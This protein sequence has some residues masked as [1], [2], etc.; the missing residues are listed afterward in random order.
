MLTVISCKSCLC[1]C[2][3]EGCQNYIGGKTYCS[4]CLEIKKT[5]KKKSRKA[6]DT[7]SYLDI[8]CYSPDGAAL[9]VRLITEVS[10]GKTTIVSET[11]IFSGSVCNAINQWMNRSLFPIQSINWDDH[12]NTSRYIMH[13]LYMCSMLNL[14]PGQC[15]WCGTLLTHRKRVKRLLCVFSRR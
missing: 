10:K 12:N 8:T 7:A 6:W 11:P 3:K 1:M 2:Q 15:S 5:K 9:G 4:E 14:G 13:S